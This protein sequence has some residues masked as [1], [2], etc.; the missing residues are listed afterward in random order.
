[1]TSDVGS[2]TL[3]Q[4]PPVNHIAIP[5]EGK[6][7]RERNKFAS[8]ICVTRSKCHRFANNGM[9]IERLR[10]AAVCSDLTLL[11]VTGATNKQMFYF[12]RCKIPDNCHLKACCKS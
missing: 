2:V 8:L 11:L 3:F 4:I 6:T 1:M 7:S 10:Q 12:S 5:T 9:R